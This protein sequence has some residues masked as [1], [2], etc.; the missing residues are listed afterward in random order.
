MSVRRSNVNKLIAAII[1]VF[2][3][4]ACGA[5]GNGGNGGA[6]SASEDSASNGVEDAKSAILPDPCE[7]IS[8]EQARTLLGVDSVRNIQRSSAPAVER[9]CI[10][11]A[12]TA[13]GTKSVALVLQMTSG[14]PAAMPRPPQESLNSM[15]GMLMAARDPVDIVKSGEQYTFVFD[16]ADTTRIRVLTNVRGTASFS[17][18]NNAELHVSLFLKDASQASEDRIAA[19]KRTIA[20]AV[21]KVAG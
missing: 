8:E 20:E 16:K 9:G 1:L 6:E 15:I 3:V 17:G 7:L 5:D 4:A 11:E 18:T 10:Y 14:M 13:A 12:S 19:A 21:E 2:S